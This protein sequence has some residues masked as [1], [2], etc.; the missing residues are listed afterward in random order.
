MAEAFKGAKKKDVE[1]VL[2]SLAA[3]GL[4]LAYDAAGG[5]RWKG[6]GA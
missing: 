6:A 3:L 5:R 4:L 1:T 2:E